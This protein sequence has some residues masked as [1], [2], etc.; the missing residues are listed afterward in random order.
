MR[1]FA[2]FVVGALLFSALADPAPLLAIS[3]GDA[4]TTSFK[5]QSEG[6]RLYKEG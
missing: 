4:R 1:P 3:A 6:M 5:L 2:C